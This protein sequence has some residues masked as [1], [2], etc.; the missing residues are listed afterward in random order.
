MS[1]TDSKNAEIL[2]T[3]SSFN[4]V[5]LNVDIDLRFYTVLFLRMPWRIT[6]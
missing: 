2:Y 3:I 1:R 5:C 4:N 6:G